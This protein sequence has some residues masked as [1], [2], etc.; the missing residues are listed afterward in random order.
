MAGDLHSHSTFSDGALPA[1]RLPW[2]AAR[3]GLRWLAVS[4]HD[5]ISS[6]R[7]ALRQPVQQGVNLI[8][9][10]E[11]TAYDPARGRRVHLLCFCP[12]DGPALQNFCALMAGRRNAVCRQSLA[13][14]QEMYA[15][16]DG[17]LAVQ[18]ASVSGVLYKTHLIR[19]LYEFGYTDGVYN[20]LYKE[21]FGSK[22]GKVLHDPAYE[23]VD[24]VLDVAKQAKAVVVL[25]HPSVYRSMELAQE[26]AAAGRIDGVEIDHPRNKPEDQQALYTLAKEYDL[27]V[28]GGTDFHGIHA[29]HPHPL[30]TCRTDDS[31]IERILRLAQKRKGL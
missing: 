3:A 29:N 20:Q 2:L 27:I 19:V 28:T 8:P 15:Q 13:A 26:L 30:G 21:L 18:N 24:T 22:G 16:F 11:L 14:L 4:D 9:A 7:F 6:V 5:S 25:A 1:A 23:T 10:T 17:D 31:Q 12:D